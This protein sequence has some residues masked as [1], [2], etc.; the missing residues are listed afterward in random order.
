MKVSLKYTVLFIFLFANFNL[1]A[2]KYTWTGNSSTAWTTSNNWSPVGVPNTTDSVKIVTRTNAPVLGANTTVKELD[3]TSGSISLS[4]YSLTVSN[5][6]YFYAGTISNGTLVLRGSNAIFNGSTLN[7]TIDAIVARVDFSGGVFNY[8]SSFEQTG[9][10]TTNGAGGC[11]FN[12]PITIKK[13]GAAY[14]TMGVSS[15]D[16]FNSTLKVI[17]T[18][19]YAIQLGYNTVASFYDSLIFEN[20]SS[21]GISI[22]GGN[23][24]GGGHIYNGKKI[25]IGTGGFTAGLLTLK[26]FVQTGTGQQ[27]FV[28]TGSAITSLAGCSFEGDLTIT[29]PGILLKTSTFN[30]TTEFIRS[31]TSSSYSDGGN[32]FNGTTTFRNNATNTASFRL[33]VQTGDQYNGNVSFI[34]TTGYIQPAYSGTS[35]F[36]GNVSISSAL[37]VFNVGTGKLLCTGTN[38]QTFSTTG[39]LT[40][41]VSKFGINKSGGSV[42]FNAPITIDSLLELT[43]GNIITSSSN[44]L[45]LKATAT[46]SG[47]STNSYIAGPIK[48]IGNS[49]FKFPL[50]KGTDYRP[51]SITAPSNATDA[52]T[53][54]YFNTVQTNGTAKDTSINYISECNYWNVA[55]TTGSSNVALTFNW[56]KSSCD[57]FDIDSTKLARWNGAKWVDGGLMNYNGNDSIGSVTTTVSLSTFGNFLFGHKLIPQLSYSYSADTTIVPYSVIITN[58]SRGFKPG[59]QFYFNNGKFEQNSTSFVLF[60]SNR[61]VDIAYPLK[62]NYLVTQMAIAGAD[63]TIISSR[64]ILFPQVASV[65]VNV[66]QQDPLLLN[67]LPCSTLQNALYTC[68]TPVVMHIQFDGIISSDVFECNIPPN[69]SLSFTNG[70]PPNGF[71]Y[72]TDGFQLSNLPPMGEMNILIQATNCSL[73]ASNLNYNS[74]FKLHSNTSSVKYFF[75]NSPIVLYNYNLPLDFV[76]SSLS[77]EIDILNPII[78]PSQIDKEFAYKE[79]LYRYYTIKAT[80]GIVDCFKLNAS[81]EGDVNV[82]EVSIL[83]NFTNTF[84]PIV[85]STINGGT[86]YHYVF[87]NPNKQG[88]TLPSSPLPNTTYINMSQLNMAN[89]AKCPTTYPYLFSNNAG[90]DDYMVIREELEV[91]QVNKGDCS[92]ST[93]VS[94]ESIYTYQIICD[95]VNACTPEKEILKLNVKC[96]QPI[97]DLLPAVKIVQGNAYADVLGVLDVCSSGSGTNVI[98]YGICVKNVT[99]NGNSVKSATIKLKSI[100]FIIDPKYFTWNNKSTGVTASPQPANSEVYLGNVLVNATVNLDYANRYVYTINLE[101]DIA[102]TS[103]DNVG[104]LQNNPNLTNSNIVN[105]FNGVSIGSTNSIWSTY[106]YLGYGDLI[107]VTLK[108]FKLI[109]CNSTAFVDPLKTDHFGLINAI[110]G[111]DIDYYNMCQ[112]SSGSNQN[113]LNETEGQWVHGTTYTGSCSSVMDPPNIEGGGISKLKITNQ[114]LTYGANDYPWNLDGMF[115]CSTRKNYLIIDAVI[116]NGLST[117]NAGQAVFNI[118]GNPYPGTVTNI[119]ANKWR[120]DFPAAF[121]NEMTVDVEVEFSLTCGSV[122]TWGNDE[123]K[124]AFY[125]VCDEANCADCFLEY[126]F[127]KA[128]VLRHCIGDCPPENHVSTVNFNTYRQS[129]GWQ[130]AS[131]YLGGLP[132]PQTSPSA[133][134]NLNG[135]YPMDDIRILSTNGLIGTNAS[136]NNYGI[137]NIGDFFFDITVFKSDWTF[138]SNPIHIDKP[139]FKNISTQ[140]SGV[141]VTFTVMYSNSSYPTTVRV[142]PSSITI[143]SPQHPISPADYLLTRLRLD[144]NCYPVDPSNNVPYSFTL[145]DLLKNCICKVDIDMN[146]ELTDFGKHVFPN[147]YLSPNPYSLALQGMFSY[148]D[149]DQSHDGTYHPSCDPWQSNIEYYQLT[150]SVDSLFLGPQTIDPWYGTH[151]NQCELMWEYRFSATGGKGYD[152]FPGEFR[153]LFRIGNNFELQ[154]S[155]NLSH[156]GMSAVTNGPLNAYWSFTNQPPGVNN[157]SISGNN[158]GIPLYDI[159][160]QERINLLFAKFRKDC[161]TPSIGENFTLDLKSGSIGFGAYANKNN[162]IISSVQK[163]YEYEF[164]G[165]NALK[166][167]YLL[168]SEFT[169]TNNAIFSKPSEYF[170]LDVLYKSNRSNVA[171]IVEGENAY[172]YFTNSNSN[173]L[174]FELFEDNG[175]IKVPIPY[176]FDA[177]NNIKI[178]ELGN[179]QSNL[180]DGTPKHYYL[181]INWSD[182]SFLNNGTQN[183]EITSHLG[184]ACQGYPALLTSPYSGSSYTC[185]E[186]NMPSYAFTLKNSVVSVDAFPVVST[187]ADCHPETLM[188]NIVA[189]EGE[190]VDGE[191]LINTTNGAQLGFLNSF[192]EIPPF[193]PKSLASLNCTYTAQGDFLYEIDYV[194]SEI[195]G[196]PIADVHFNA[197][198]FNKIQCTLDVYTSYGAQNVVSVFARGYDMCGNYIQEGNN[199]PTTINNT[200]STTLGSVAVVGNNTIC[201]SGATTLSVVTTIAS[202]TYLWSDQSTAS[203]LTVNSPGI[204]QVI[205]YDPATQCNSWGTIVVTEQP[206]VQVPSVLH[207]DCSGSSVSLTA[208][209]NCTSC[210][211]IWNDGQ[212]TPTIQAT[213][214]VYTVTVTNALGCTDQASCTVIDNS[215]GVDWSSTNQDFFC[216]GTPFAG[217]PTLTFSFVNPSSSLFGF[218]CTLPNG[219]IVQSQSVLA[220]FPGTYTVYATNGNGCT[221][222]SS[223]DVSDI[224]PSVSFPLAIVTVPNAGVSV[225]LIPTVSGLVSPSYAWSDGW[226]SLNNTVTAIAPT[227]TYTITV[228]NH[229]S[230]GSPCSVSASVDLVIDINPISCVPFGNTLEQSSFDVEGSSGNIINIPS[231]NYDLYSNIIIDDEVHIGA[232]ANFKI[233]NDISITIVSGG[234]LIIDDGA[235]F[236]S[237][238]G[239]MWEGFRL[240]PGSGFHANGK[241]NSPFLVEDAKF[242]IDANETATL[243]TS[244]TILGNSIFNANRVGIYLHDG[245]FDDFVFEGIMRCDKFLFPPF[246][247]NNFTKYSLVHLKLS[248]AGSV[249]LGKNGIAGIPAVSFYEAFTCINSEETN[250]YVDGTLF[251]Q[252]IVKSLTFAQKINRAAIQF[253]GKFSGSSNPNSSKQLYLGVNSSISDPNKFDKCEIGVKVRGRVVFKCF[254][255]LFH[256]SNIGIDAKSNSRSSVVNNSGQIMIE[257]NDFQY[258]KIGIE[259][260]NNSKVYTTVRNNHFNIFNGYQFDPLLED[261]KAI[262]IH[263][264]VPAQMEA[265]TV[266]IAENTIKNYRFGI[267]VMNQKYGVISNNAVFFD[268]PNA[269]LNYSTN[270]FRKGYI[271]EE[272]MSMAIFNNSCTRLINGTTST[273][274]I[275]HTIDPAN[276]SDTRS[277][278]VGFKEASS[279]NS[280]KENQ[281]NNLPSAFEVVDNC[282]NATFECNEMN[283]GIEGFKM[284]NAVIPD[285]G[286]L[287][288]PNGNKWNSWSGATRINGTVVGSPLVKWYH[289]ALY[290][291]IEDP[292]YNLSTYPG[293][294]FPISIPYA[295]CTIN[296]CLGCDIERLAQLIAMADTMDYQSELRYA[297]EHYVYLNLKDS[298][299]LMY[300]GSIYDASLQNFFTAVSLNTMGSLENVNELLSNNNYASA[301]FENNSI[302]ALRLQEQNN[303]NINEICARVNMNFENLSDNDILILE[304]IAYQYPF[305][306]GEGVYRARAILGIDLDDTTIGYRQSS[307]PLPSK[308]SKLVLMPNPNTGNFKIFSTEKFVKGTVISITDQTGRCVVEFTVENETNILDESLPTIQAGVYY[309][310]AVTGKGTILTQKLVIVK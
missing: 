141:G 208:A 279:S 189:T 184:L 188:T 280:Y 91:Q 12:A 237:C 60:S 114:L 252:P 57:V 142:L 31:S 21:S 218:Y 232:N 1:F 133:T 196:I 173:T 50:G 250:L 52:F 70:I 181:R 245:N 301:Y 129:F 209:S 263:N 75:N 246:G 291:A 117:Y 124:I 112:I 268:I 155:S 187:V 239:A 195:T 92:T 153:P 134:P 123:F 248:N 247:T 160:G 225:T 205:V 94:D 258:V 276:P 261:E 81:Y 82:K 269:A 108:G 186:F 202:P 152:E 16:I 157:Y 266:T 53:A 73:V 226:T 97:C 27:T 126:G 136:P 277:L 86:D 113:Y 161:S 25:A 201:S 24:N 175:G 167:D 214:G 194:I 118:N 162:N 32:V 93:Y 295:S 251:S 297:V 210:S 115:N 144:P 63:T 59:T 206:S 231:G 255:G 292:G 166:D 190:V 233:M 285:Q 230:N 299:Q 183:F 98:N 270:I 103:N 19:T 132:M 49:T 219:S 170:P 100:S 192:F 174:E 9:T 294:I 220:Q 43:S 127:S 207:T 241:S 264:A 111:Y 5:N 265:P 165:N 221:V 15:A 243:N 179:P 154:V 147:D 163:Q 288:A 304:S 282:V 51:V 46:L 45:T 85:T 178:F 102:G 62:K 116:A 119:S 66:F 290:P 191:I 283:N 272:C 302:Y 7:V 253:N 18:A 171:S 172:I 64:L 13:S 244:I 242:A 40:Y 293:G 274:S 29:S 180:K 215:I 14:L 99:P 69:V 137:S 34:T 122:P 39:S 30:G 309:V 139:I 286:S 83:N 296:P 8:Q 278:L 110:I 306:G 300:S 177:A 271:A 138:N 217:Y 305:I 10:S 298:L 148:N 257:N 84:S 156:L 38:N 47:G 131:D 28:T 240:L 101:E 228:T 89:Q 224:T 145:S 238:F 74:G 23:A 78:Y 193:T 227:T 90:D 54:E 4:G 259:L 55:R 17:N 140:N 35:E 72:T 164:S 169:T 56:Y 284:V 249:Y 37:V 213:A 76:K 2:T 198:D 125:Q 234:Q 200:Y 307:K 121:Q 308:S 3:L 11:T 267:Q 42:T 105:N 197:N 176:S 44:L 185:K 33:G 149:Y 36:K 95:G 22:G 48:K 150:Y 235:H 71:A 204:Y 199:Q 135:Y 236:Y 158:I 216:N 273:L 20:S 6:A 87:Y 146:L 109:D 182:C 67:P 159:W 260:A 65:S 58:T 80:E 88:W 120:V 222:S 275:D 107:G 289:S 223:F 26:N 254:N 79:T 130:S 262:Y 287:S 212:T 211:F 128:R 203:T 96:L 310:K 229:S 104:F 41:L 168:K 281:T 303:T 77:S 151:P 106:S 68:F 256:D 61:K 143:S